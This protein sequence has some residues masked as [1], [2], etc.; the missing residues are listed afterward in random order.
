MKKL[1]CVLMTMIIMVSSVITSKAS[2]ISPNEVRFFL[3]DEI[4]QNIKQNDSINQ[5]FSKQNSLL[6]EY[7]SI[8]E[9]LPN[10]RSGG[11]FFDDD[12]F[13]HILIT[14][15]ISDLISSRDDLY[16]DLVKY[17]YNQLK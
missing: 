11:A 2:N 17:S 3:T 15:E 9:S 12:G 5:A 7:S 13:L 6:V 14:E 1:I 16:F 8:L 4:Y 10:E